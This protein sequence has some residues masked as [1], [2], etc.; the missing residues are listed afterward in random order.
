MGNKYSEYK[1]LHMETQLNP[2]EIKAWHKKFKKD[3]PHGY[4]TK[5]DFW[6]IFKNNPNPDCDPVEYVDH[7]FRVYDRDGNGHIDFAEFLISLCTTGMGNPEEKVRWLFKMYDIDGNG[8]I[9]KQEAVKVIKSVLKFEGADCPGQ[10]AVDIVEYLFDELD[11]N[12]DERL[13]EEEYVRGCLATP[14]IM[15]LFS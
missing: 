15:E 6:D 10:K 9:T 2:K 8:Y 4:M 13:S 5:K 7:V 14:N 12:K 3:Y 1:S 11:T